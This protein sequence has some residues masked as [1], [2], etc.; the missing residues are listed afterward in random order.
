MTTARLP[1]HWSI[2][3]ACLALAIFG[4]AGCKD[5]SGCAVDG[6]GGFDGGAGSG[7]GGAAG[8]GGSAV[9]GGAKP[10]DAIAK[11]P[12]NLQVLF[13]G[14]FMSELYD[15]LS[16]NLE[17]EI[18]EA[19]QRAA[20]SLNVHIELPGE[21]S[22]DIAIGDAIANALPRIVLP[23]EPGRFTSF[24]TQMRSLEAEGAAYQNIS[25]ASSSFDTSQSVEH[26]AAAILELLRSTDKRV[27]IVTHSKGGLDTLEALLDAPELWG[28]KVIGWVALQAPFF[29]SPV[30]DPAP[31]V[32]NDALL[33][34]VGGHGQ[35]LDDLKTV[36]RALY[37]EANEEAIARLTASIPVIAAYTTYEARGTV[38]DFAREFASGIFGPGLIS[39]IT[40]LV[41]ESYKATPRNLPRVIA[42]STT[43]AIKLV[44][45]R[46]E[47]ALSEAIGTIG[48][49]T[50]TNVYLKDVLR[51]PNDGLVPKD[52][53]VLPGAIHREL[54]VGDHASPVMDVD[55]FK[56]FWTAEQRN[57]ITLE[58]ITEVQHLAADD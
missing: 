49:L 20:R 41:V 18:N 19:L 45:Q 23:I 56:N 44:R 28:N 43:A 35:S 10:A 17:N 6:T 32:I 55:P 5:C 50:L 14:G 52:S 40:D 51:I 27:V 53:T 3:C 16:T 7:A 29:G 15:E 38:R 42:A 21:K 34:A 30:A 26:N 48:L 4:S 2:L 54:P 31:S 13:V 9:V 37:M 8:A 33:G 24:Y 11:L 36:T 1:K 12:K 57:Q 58:L 39:E 47:D 25:I 46:V 22:I